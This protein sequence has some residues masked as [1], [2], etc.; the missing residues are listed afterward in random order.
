MGWLL[1][2]RLVVKSIREALQ[3]FESRKILARLAR[4]HLDQELSLARHI[5]ESFLPPAKLEIGF[6]SVECYRY[7]SAHL[8]GHWFALRSDGADGLYALMCET[9]DLGIHGAMILHAVQSLWAEDLGNSTLDPEAWLHKT[10]RALFVLGKSEIHELEVS[11]VHVSGSRM[12]YWGGGDRVLFQVAE[13]QLDLP[14]LRPL[15]RGSVIL[16]RSEHIFPTATT[17]ALHQRDRIFLGNRSLFPDSDRYEAKDVLRLHLEMRV[18]AEV[19]T[20]REGEEI[21]RSLVVISRRPT[22][23]RVLHLKQA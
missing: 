1:Q 9:S 6:Y 18:L 19:A 5:E 8:G 20:N 12:T 3:E 14:V 22:S 15:A 7:K 4:V 16:G 13:D 17:V 23:G 2:T 11:L 10:N 21:G